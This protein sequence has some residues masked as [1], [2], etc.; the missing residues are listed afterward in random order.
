MRVKIVF[1]LV[2]F[3]F[4]TGALPVYADESPGAVVFDSSLPDEGGYFQV[5][6]TISNMEFIAC[7]FVLRYDTDAIIPV[8]AEGQTAESFWDFANLKVGWLTTVGTNVDPDNGLIDFSLFLMPGVENEF[9][10]PGQTCV[11]V[12]NR[13]LTV[14]TF[15]F[16]RLRDGAG[17]W[18]ASEDKDVPY[19][20]ACPDGV[21]ISD[22]D[23]RVAADIIFREH[24]QSADG[25]GET[26]VERIEY[27]RDVGSA[28]DKSVQNLLE[29]IIMLKIDSHAAV[30]GG[31]VVAIYPGERLVTAYIMD[32]RTFVPVRFIAQ[33]LGAAVTWDDDTQTVTIKKDSHVVS[34]VVGESVCTVDGNE[35]AIDAPAQTVPAADGYVR[36][37]VPIR[38]ISEGLGCRV[39]W[40][41]ERRTVVIM[42]EE[43][44]WTADGEIETGAIEEADRRL[45]LYGNFV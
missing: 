14:F 44:D 4:F 5:T 41:D 1:V 37:M 35:I 27:I 33:R 6:M 12:D 38:F 8:N 18:I 15:T 7:Q 29:N 34:M 40:D 19:S 43:L 20:E 11:T 32:N 22:A 9:V 21:I 45:T 2:L 28:G 36:T 17:L 23:G 42:S 26:T 10:I 25:E 30:V 13:E 39:E 24:I 31:E 16:Q 3:A